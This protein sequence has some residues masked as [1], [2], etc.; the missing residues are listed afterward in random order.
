MRVSSWRRD[1]AQGLGPDAVVDEL[2]QQ[3]QALMPPGRGQVAAVG[4][5]RDGGQ[6]DHDGDAD[7]AEPH[8]QQQSDGPCRGHDR[9]HEGGHEH[10]AH[11][12]AGERAARAN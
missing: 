5:T 10:V 2:V 1:V 6:H 4:D 12:G 8:Q 9:E 7:R 11:V 3:L